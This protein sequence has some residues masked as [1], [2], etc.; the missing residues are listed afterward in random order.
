MSTQPTEPRSGALPCTM[1]L[2][3]DSDATVIALVE[4][5]YADV[6]RPEHFTNHLHCDECAEHDHTLLGGERGSLSLEHVGKPE[7]DPLSFCT[8]QGKAYY[9][10]DLIR[11]AL[12]G[13][14]AHAPPYWRQ[15]LTH[16]AGDGPRNALIAY[17]TPHQRQA[18]AAFLEH[19]INTRPCE[20][21]LHDSTDEL[22]RVHGYWTNETLWVGQTDTRNA[23]S[24]RGATHDT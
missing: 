19:L 6:A 11:L 15:L 8:P 17:C 10:P 13:S 18:V 16:L 3:V 14:A 22:L 7:W 23:S 12:A 21:E 5:A 20:V 1:S 24:D 4:A 9:M 2:G